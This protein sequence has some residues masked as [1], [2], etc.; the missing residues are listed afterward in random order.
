[1]T[2]VASARVLILTVL[3]LSIFHSACGVVPTIEEL[4]TYFEI[5][6]FKSKWVK[7]YYSPWPEKLTLAPEISFQVKN[8]SDK[9]LKFVYFNAIFTL[10]GVKTVQGDALYSALTKEPLMPGEV[11]D[12]ITMRSN[13]G[14]EGNRLSDFKDNPAWE[15]SSVK[16]FVKLKGSRYAQ[17]GE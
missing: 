11:S 4:K 17:L 14:V 13:Y 5:I 16:L 9:P 3:A 2:K 6:D 8:L 7:K 1:M 15:I 10:K 12:V